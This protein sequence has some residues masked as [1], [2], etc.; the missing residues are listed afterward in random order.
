MK[1]YIELLSPYSMLKIYMNIDMFCL[2]TGMH[3]LIPVY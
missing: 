1:T 3:S 2:K